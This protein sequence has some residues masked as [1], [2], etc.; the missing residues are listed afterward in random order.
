MLWMLDRHTNVAHVH[1]LSHKEDFVL[2]Q[3][4][5]SNLGFGSIIQ[6]SSHYSRFAVQDKVWSSLIT[7][8]FNGRVFPTR[9]QY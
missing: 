3:Y 5:R 4:I 7:D 9:T 2:L 1:S 8:I 6:Q